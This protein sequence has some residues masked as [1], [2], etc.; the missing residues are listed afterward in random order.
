MEQLNLFSDIGNIIRN[1]WNILQGKTQTGR[2]RWHLLE[3]GRISNEQ[4]HSLYGIRHLPRR[5]MDLEEELK[6]E[7]SDYWIDHISKTGVN[8]FGEKC[9]FVDYTLKQVERVGA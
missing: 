1:N 6:T 3:F 5:I 9:I 7:N 2:I 4:A 8:R